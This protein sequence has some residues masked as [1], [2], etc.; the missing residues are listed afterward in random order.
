VR[1][2]DGG[3]ICPADG[4]A[5]P[6]H[7]SGLLDLRPPAGRAAADLF[8]AQY[9]AGRLADG[10]QP[11]SSDAACALP[12]GDPPGFTQLYWTVRRESWAALTVLLT[13]FGTAP[14]A[15]ADLGAGFPWL[16]HRLASLGH[17]VL[18]VDL[19][20]DID[21]GLGAARLFP[22]ARLRKDAAGASWQPGGFLPI[23][24]D[25][26]QPPLA[27]A[28]YDV[29][30]CNASLHYARDLPAAV[31][32]MAQTLRPAAALVILDSP[33]VS[34][35]HPAK[36]GG[37]VLDRVAV[38]DALTQAGLS[39]AWHPVPRGWLWRRHQGKNWLLRRPQFD[40]PIIVGRRASAL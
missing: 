36:G 38:D 1:N 13:E 5:F 27:A 8:A 10:W 18:A 19:S 24:G 20:P 2:A 37:R 23:L 32:R 40:F 4:A 30:I 35:S 12:G 25:L 16:S 31:A 9:R 7:P 14:L 21:F 34:V 11:L 39:A 33:I 22:T 17:A 26:E 29:V 28:A 3:L 15:I 6:L